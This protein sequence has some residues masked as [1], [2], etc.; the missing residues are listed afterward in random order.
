MR[1]LAATIAATG[2]VVLLAACGG[3]G[4]KPTPSSAQDPKLKMA[5]CFSACT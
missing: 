3:S 1:L 2:C 5:E 4:S